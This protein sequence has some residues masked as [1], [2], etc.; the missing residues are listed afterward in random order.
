MKFL[1]SGIWDSYEFFLLGCIMFIPGSYHTFLAMMA[2]RQV[3][4]YNYDEV[5]IF[6][7][8]FNKED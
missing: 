6:D 8:D 7:E 5:A 4:G 2:F 3:P 1:E